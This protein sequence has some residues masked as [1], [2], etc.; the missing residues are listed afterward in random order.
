MRIF[1]DINH[2]GHVHYFRN[3]ISIMQ[4]H[5]HAFFITTRDK[6]VS[7]KLLEEYNLPYF[8]RG[9][10]YNGLLGK[11]LYMFKADYVL[12]KKA[13]VFK[14]DIFLSFGI[15]Y[16]AQASSFLRKPHI[17]FDDTEHAWFQQLMNNPFS[18]V[19]LT[20]SCF[21]KSFGKK[22]IRFES[23]MELA[24][25]H[26]HY[27]TPNPDI[28]QILGLKPEEKF[29]LFRFVSWN[30]SHDIGQKGMPY[31]EKARLINELSKY[32]K[33]LISSEAELPFNLKQYQIMVPSHRMHDVQAFASLFIGEGATMASECAVLGTPAIYINSLAVGY[34]TEE[35]D[36]Y[37]LVFN[38]RTPTGILEKAL[39]LIKM[40]NLHEVFQQ[41]RQKLLNDKIDLTAFM[42]WFVEN[43][44]QSF[45]IMKEDPE[46]QVRFKSV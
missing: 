30:A 13:K 19:V 37:Q 26:Q 46:Y 34:C 7:L 22:Q 45:K 21:T 4:S 32:A 24:A 33:V 16:A 6:E 2:P 8:N 38:F 25:L 27:Y 40:P 5:G 43:Y 41:R 3:F 35:E 18:E 23:Y 9:K 44:P 11:M 29:I 36:K 12:Y 28:Y 39:E 42:V 14:P 31:S 10:G 15:M 20:P 17:A 1:I